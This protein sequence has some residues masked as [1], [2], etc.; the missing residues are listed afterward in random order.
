M[1]LKR[2]SSKYQMECALK[3]DYQTQ[4]QSS[5]AQPNRSLLSSIERE[6]QKL[7]IPCQEPTETDQEVQPNVNSKDRQ[8]QQHG[9]SP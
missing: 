5:V 2:S 9:R 1:S 4:T 7:E 3:S 6:T 8:Q